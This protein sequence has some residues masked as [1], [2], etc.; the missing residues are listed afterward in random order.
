MLKFFAG[1]VRSTRSPLRVVCAIVIATLSV[2]V[3]YQDQ[4]SVAATP[5]TPPLITLTVG[6]V[7]ASSMQLLCSSSCEGL[8]VILDPRSSGGWTDRQ[9]ACYNRWICGTPF[10]DPTGKLPACA[11]ASCWVA[12]YGAG[13]VAQVFSVVNQVLG[14]GPY[15]AGYMDTTYTPFSQRLDFGLPVV[16]T[17][18]TFEHPSSGVFRVT[19]NVASGT[20]PLLVNIDAENWSQYIDGGVLPALERA[21]KTCSALTTCS[22]SLEPQEFY[23]VRAWSEG[24]SSTYEGFAA[25]DTSPTVHAYHGVGV[26]WPLNLVYTSAWV[27]GVK[28]GTKVQ[29]V[30]ANKLFTC[31]ANAIGSC[32][33][34][35]DLYF[36][37]PQNGRIPMKLLI[38]GKYT[39]AFVPYSRVK[40]P[41][42]MKS[43]QT[44]QLSVSE[45]P[46]GA[47][48]A[49][50][51][52][53]Q[54]VSRVRLA[55]FGTKVVSI[56]VQTKG[57]HRIDVYVGVMRVASRYIAF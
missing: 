45:V 11:I 54:V 14:A 26:V 10:T 34:V 38:N 28:E 2:V 25:L 8:F 29:A 43:R 9:E 53:R 40:F 16:N 42:S 56:P 51:I 19:A 27:S 17:W 48:I 44:N 47:E 7:T 12:G 46:S 24:W 13:R 5:A 55:K 52:D 39:A 57:F 4:K 30:V 21:N 33:L 18:M 23:R 3:L 37:K 50:V 35:G 41:A 1:I 32:E 31:K 6:H 15:S 49:L 22:V 36:T 20:A